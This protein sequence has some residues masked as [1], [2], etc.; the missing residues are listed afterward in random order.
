MPNNH[1]SPVTRMAGSVAELRLAAQTARAAGKSIGVVPTMGALHAGHLSLVEASRRECGFTV[2]TIFVNP[3][4]FAQGEDLD[5]YPRE[6]E[7]DLRKLAGAG[8]DLAFTPADEDVY[9]EGFSTFVE[10]T[11]LTN[12]LE[13]RTR[14]EHFRGVTT[15]VLKLFN[16]VQPDVAYFGQKDF[17]QARVI[18]RMALDLNV[19]IEIRMQPIIRDADGLALSSRNAYL[20]A[21]QRR[22]GLALSGSL[23]AATQMFATGETNAAAILDC[24]REV[25]QA[26]P[27]IEMDYL[28][29]VDPDSLLAVSEV[30]ADVVALVAAKVGDVR[31]IDNARLGDAF[32][33]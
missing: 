5:Q 14:P 25:F 30:D 15:I 21:D 1:S 18:R 23:R 16:M 28:A 19:P 12:V 8:A 10:V 22:Q 20:S 24:M 2:V 17:Q 31:L 33:S 13:G 6:Q 3:L 9:P 26:V 7:E 32:P 11:G 27:E 4:Q 29:L